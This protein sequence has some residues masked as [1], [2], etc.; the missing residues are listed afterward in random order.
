MSC[1]FSQQPST[2]ALI[3]NIFGAITPNSSN[4]LNYIRPLASALQGVDKKIP[5]FDATTFCFLLVFFIQ[6]LDNEM[7]ILLLF[8][9][10]FF[11]A[12]NS[13]SQSIYSLLL[14]LNNCKNSRKDPFI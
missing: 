14:I 2:P 5:I 9:S 13:C 4:S 8:S 7:Q 1:T 10:L 6:T 3:P 11:F 12:M